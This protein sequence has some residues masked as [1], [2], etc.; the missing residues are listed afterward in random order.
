MKKETK[1]KLATVLVILCIIAYLIC[2]YPAIV[3]VDQY[4]KAKCQS[5]IGI[6]VGC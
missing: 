5:I 1:N 6:P 3:S 2:L 4:G